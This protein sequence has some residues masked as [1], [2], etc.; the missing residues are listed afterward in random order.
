MKKFNK[1]YLLVGI[2]LAISI[3]A[4]AL[5]GINKKELILKIDDEDIGEEEYFRAMS[6]KINE[7]K[8]EYMQKSGEKLPPD[9]W[10]KRQDGEDPI[11][12]L[13]E[14]SLEEIKE[15]K[16]IYILAKEN[17]NVDTTNF[18]HIEKRRQ[19]ENKRLKEENGTTIF[20]TEQ[21]SQDEFEF[22][23]VRNLRL[24][25]I[26]SSN[27]E[28]L[29]V[30][31]DEIRAHFNANIE[32]LKKTDVEY[33][34]N[35]VRVENPN[36]TQKSEYQDL[37]KELSANKR[38]DDIIDKYPTLKSSYQRADVGENSIKLFEERYPKVY[39]LN[40]S[41]DSDNSFAK[42]VSNEL[43]VLV[44]NTKTFISDEELFEEKKEEIR[45]SLQTIKYAS[46]VKQRA[47]LLKVEDDEENNIE[48]TKDVLKN[49][50]KLN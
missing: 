43:L 48:F 2:I 47:K 46:L 6:L 38:L 42:E 19:E 37:V 18:D 49:T 12:T 45:L 23:E 3:L 29:N 10:F 40:G 5:S 21:Y 13:Y 35:F 27:N 28:E 11:K 41:I 14:R 34:I 22:N 36:E 9:F 20:G 1:L 32:S 16:T 17:G 24:A 4:F 50:L 7:V 33:T 44:Q 8:N 39:E 25:Y 15:F 30:S 26:Q 31:D